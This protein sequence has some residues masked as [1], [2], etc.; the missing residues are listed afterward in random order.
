MARHIMAI[1]YKPKIESI[2][3]DTCTQTIRKRRKKPFAIGDLILLHGWEG[4]PYWSRWS[5]RKLVVI[6]EVIDITIY[7]DYVYMNYS[8]GS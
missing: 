2:L 5:W 1:T 7:E 8:D 4:R 3:K 6:S